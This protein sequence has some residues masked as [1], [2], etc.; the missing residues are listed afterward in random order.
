MVHMVDLKEEDF[1][2]KKERPAAVKDGAPV[3][4]SKCWETL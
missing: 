3:D 1:D 4:R 2:T